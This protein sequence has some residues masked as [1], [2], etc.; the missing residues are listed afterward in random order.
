MLR[1]FSKLNVTS[2][3]GRKRRRNMRVRRPHK[4][5]DELIDN[6]S[7][8]LRDHTERETV[9]VVNLAVCTPPGACLDEE[10]GEDLRDSIDDD[11]DG[12]FLWRFNPDLS[13][14][15]VELMQPRFPEIKFFAK[16]THR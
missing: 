12:V 1:L 14:Q 11:E 3:T 10:T 8:A 4:T 5:V 13:R 15:A 9:R 16:D 6:Y 2:A 7:K